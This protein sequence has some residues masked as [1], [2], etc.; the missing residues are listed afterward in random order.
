VFVIFGTRTVKTPIRNGLKLRRVCGRCR[1][2]SQMQEYRSREYFTLFFIPIFPV[3]KG[4]GL[5]V[6][7]RCRANFYIQAEDYVHADARDGSYSQ[8]DA[9][10]GFSSEE[11]I[12]VE[13]ERCKGKLRVPVRLGHKLAITCPHC[14]EEFEFRVEKD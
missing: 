11:K 13:C 6:C 10:E 2:L 5:L 7:E 14:R 9:Q 1:L 4:E 12:V 8:G 3:S